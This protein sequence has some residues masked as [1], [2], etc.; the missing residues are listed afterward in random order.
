MTTN[1]LLPDFYVAGFR[2]CG[3]TTICDWLSQHPQIC[4]PYPKEPNV[5]AFDDLDSNRFTFFEAKKRWWEADFEM[6]PK[7]ELSRYEQVFKNYVDGQLKFDGTPNYITSIKA[8]ERIKNYTPNAKFIIMLRHPFKRAISDFKFTVRQRRASYS[9]EGHIKY[10][11]TTVLDDSLYLK[12]IKNLFRY[13]SSENI[14]ILTLEETISNEQAV[15]HQISEFL[16]IKLWTP[17]KQVKN[18]GQSF[19]SYKLQY[20]LNRLPKLWL[21]RY[22]TIEHYNEH[23]KESKDSFF[24]KSATIFINRLGN[25]NKTQKKK[26]PYLSKDFE[27]QLQEYFIRENRGLSSL[28]NKDLKAIWKLEI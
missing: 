2:K 12:H 19:H 6:C 17:N 5:F 23:L 24:K 20:A 22:N 10:E 13:F 11:H 9:L 14:L 21:S 18:T 3:T 7:R 26:N 25:L 4:K 15:I 28:I 16:E 1:K 27:E 8:L